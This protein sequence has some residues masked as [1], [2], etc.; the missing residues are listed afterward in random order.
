MVDELGTEE[1]MPVALT[2]RA[3]LGLSAAYICLGLLVRGFVEAE[4]FLPKVEVFEGV[5]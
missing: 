4:A 5:I 3:R 1:E 2:L